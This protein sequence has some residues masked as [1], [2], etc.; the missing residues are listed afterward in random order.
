[1]SLPNYSPL[2]PYLSYYDNFN[3]IPIIHLPSKLS[4]FNDYENEMITYS[5]P[6]QTVNSNVE[7]EMQSQFRE[8][9]NETSR[10]P[11]MYPNPMFPEPF[12]GL[13]Y[14]MFFQNPS[15]EM[16]Q[17]M[18]YSEPFIGLAY[19]MMF[20]EQFSGMKYS[21][22]ESI[23]INNESIEDQ[24]K[25]N[26]FARK[27]IKKGLPDII[28]IVLDDLIDSMITDTIDYVNMFDIEIDNLLTIFKDSDWIPKYKNCNCCRG[29]ITDCNCTYNFNIKYC[30]CFN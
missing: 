18:F 21:P 16:Q 24:D 7:P 15:G 29:Y 28:N 14:P 3:D 12:V 6:V 11:T 5:D 10:R 1:M 19:P 4:D 26:K 20:P 17:P 2:I 13:V 25:I 9:E 30:I 22:I 27:T 23:L 8:N